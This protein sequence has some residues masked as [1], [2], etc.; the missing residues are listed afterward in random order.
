MRTAIVLAG[1][2]LTFVG[3]AGG[4]VNQGAHSNALTT[5]RIQEEQ[6]AILE[7]QL[8]DA[9][10]NLDA[11]K[12]EI[13]TLQSQIGQLGSAIDAQAN[14]SADWMRNLSQT[15]FG[16]LPLELEMQLEQLEGSN[17][18]LLTFDRERGILRFSSDLSFD[19]G[20]DKLRP[21]VI[22]AIRALAGILEAAMRDEPFE[23]H[24]VGH[25]D[26]VPVEKPSTKRHH[27][28]NLHLSVHRAISVR[29]ALLASG[30]D[31]DRM[32]VG[33]YGE[34][35]PLV[36]NPAKGAAENRRVEVLLVP[37][38]T[39]AAEPEPVEPEQPYLDAPSK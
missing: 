17:P 32:M 34:H 11:A 19:S 2:G 5:V 23:V 37:V 31:P 21:A 10:T 27:P 20:S 28:T 12:A 6:I 24:L 7:G 26:N 8:A 16:I 38:R 35:R 39:A 1:A 4:C 14:K 18:E 22:E 25:T 33:G 9:S 3:F 29:D 36:P 30:I 13:T 15:S